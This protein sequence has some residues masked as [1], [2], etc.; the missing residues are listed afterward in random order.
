MRRQSQA[1]IVVSAA[2][3]ALV[4]LNLGRAEQTKLPFTPGETLTYEITWKVFSAGE[5]IASLKKVGEASRDDYEVKAAA[6]SHG[7]ASLLFKVENEFDAVFDPQTLCSHQIFK[8]V[9]EGRRHKETHIAFDAARRLAI[10][11][12]RDLADPTAPPKHAENEIPACAQDIVSAFYFIRRQ[13]LHVGRQLIVNINDGSKT[14]QVLVDVQAR[15]RI[16]TPLGS[17]IA[18]RVEPKVFGGLYRRK[19]RMLIWFSDDEQRLPLRVK[20]MISVGTITGTLK[21]VTL[22]P[23]SSLARKP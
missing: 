12:E 19:G 8:R 22:D 10:L 14:R 6:R 9:N 2:F 5:V 23:A 18:F 4:N 16:E 7:F 3:V 20:A 15:E 21:S 17:R 13:P 1:G 11:D